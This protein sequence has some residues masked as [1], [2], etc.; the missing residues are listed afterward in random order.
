[1]ARPRK[2]E[3][4]NQQFNLSLTEHE[5]ASIKRRA[6][7]IGMHPAHF[8]RA[9]LIDEARKLKVTRVADDGTQRLVYEQLSRLGNLLNQ[10]VRHLHQTGEPLPGDL[11]PLLAD[12][13]QI[14]A[15]RVER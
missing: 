8:G 4:R 11:Q 14:I 10:I 15:R 9:L 2:S 5:L 7:A 3:P 6:S 13:R 1:M 12:I